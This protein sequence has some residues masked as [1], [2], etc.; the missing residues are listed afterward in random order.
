M[1]DN[2]TIDLQLDNCLFF[3]SCK[4]ARVLGKTAD[5]AFA[6]TGLSPSHAF[7]LTLVNANS[8]IHQK[9]I[10]ELLHMTPSTI[11]RFVEKLEGKKLVTRKPEGKNVY[12]FA[13]EKGILLQP[14]IEKAWKTIYDLYANILTPEESQQFSSIVSKLISHLEEKK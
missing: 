14:E 4:L 2:P 5:E 11:T 9:E 7:L 1:N 6:V 13:T 3:S 8:G 12:L 10:G